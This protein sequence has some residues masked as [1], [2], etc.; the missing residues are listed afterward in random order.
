[1]AVARQKEPSMTTVS[2]RYIV[3]DV[4]AALGFYCDQLGFGVVMRPAPGFAMLSRDDL[5]LLL[6][7]PSG[8]G[9]GGQAMPDGRR[10]EPGGWNRFQLQVSGLPAEVDRLRA[11]GVRFRNEIVHGVGGDQILAEDPAGNLV[12]LF[13]A[14]R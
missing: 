7:A 11:A 4:D 6:S 9:G 5:R 3:D 10:P 13:E 1:M 14:R 8:E 2:V 12:E